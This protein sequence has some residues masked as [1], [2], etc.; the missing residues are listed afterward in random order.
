MYPPVIENNRTSSNVARQDFKPLRI[1][2]VIYSLSLKYGGPPEGL[3]QIAEGYRKEGIH[4]E[5]VT[6]DAPD[7][8]FLKEIAFPVHALGPVKS[9]Y[10]YTPHLRPWLRNNVQAYDAIVIHGL[11]QYHS[12]ATWRECKDKVPYATFVH[13]A[14]DP[15]FKKQYPLKHFK[16]WLYWRVFQYPVLRDAIAVLFTTQPER[17]QALLSFKVNHWKSVIVPYGT[18]PPAG[19]PQAQR[20]AFIAVCPPVRDRRFL[21]FMGRIHEKKGCD[22]L[23]EAFAR[24]APIASGTHLVLAG[25]DQLGWKAVLEKRAQ[26]LGISERIHYPG[27]LQ[28]DE[29][30]GAFYAAEAFILPSH[31]EN[32]GIAVAEAM[33]CG[34]AVLISNKVNIWQDIAADNAGIVDEDTVEGTYRM[35]EQWLRMPDH[36]RR[37]M[38][39][40]ASKSFIRRYSMHET[41]CALEK[42]FRQ[43]LKVNT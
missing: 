41:A 40:N 27:M 11:W 2:H 5:V 20:E 30:W 28:G 23:I 4:L 38:A 25:P 1:L 43:H 19:D 34:K 13:G 17:D 36:E 22:L 21:L 6:L 29:K 16:K 37:L 10:G 42:L 35:L 8:E 7:E 33:A 12:L 24:I 15:W 26:E 3:R 39:N 18:N 14:L 9:V 32:F 31:Q